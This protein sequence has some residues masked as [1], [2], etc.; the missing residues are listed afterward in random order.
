[1]WFNYFLVGSLLLL[2][3]RCAPV[4]IDSV[5]ENDYDV[6]LINDSDFDVEDYAG[7]GPIKSG[8]SKTIFGQVRTDG[9]EPATAKTCC[10]N[11][12]PPFLYEKIFIH[13]YP[14]SAPFPPSTSVDTRY[15]KAD[16]KFDG[17]HCVYF[18]YSQ[19]HYNI[20]NYE[21]K[22]LGEAHIQF[23]YRVTNEIFLKAEACKPI[24]KL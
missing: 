22:D 23:T 2:F 8:E 14:E 24:Q 12:H 17:S 10:I 5:T 11:R 18:K 16:I 15:S 3:D 20:F 7:F 19:G 6:V 13:N 1:M 9:K 21:R 4:T